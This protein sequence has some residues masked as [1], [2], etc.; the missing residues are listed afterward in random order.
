MIE[1]SLKL[2]N[3]MTNSAISKLLEK[4][5]KD[6][7]GLTAN[8]DIAE[9]KMSNQEEVNY[10]KGI[11]EAEV[12]IHIDTTVTLKQKELLDLIFKKVE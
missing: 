5:I 3:K 4:I 9:F 8:I 10:A 1:V 2:L 7:A 11:T 12:T 6:K